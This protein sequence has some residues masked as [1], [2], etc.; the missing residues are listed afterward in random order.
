MFPYSSQGDRNQTSHGLQIWTLSALSQRA[1]KAVLKLTSPSHVL[2]KSLCRHV[3]N[4]IESDVNS[5]KYKFL[6][7][8][9]NSDEPSLDTVDIYLYSYV[10]PID[11]KR[12]IVSGTIFILAEELLY[13]LCFVVKLFK[14]VEKL[15]SFLSR[16]RAVNHL[17]WSFCERVTLRKHAAARPWPLWNQMRSG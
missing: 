2:I 8:F 14:M 10:F 13:K 9:K 11:L 4:V 5:W 3:L 17:Q 16:P 12:C 1:K 6:W 15:V 7:Q